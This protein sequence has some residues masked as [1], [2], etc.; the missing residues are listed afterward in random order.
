M[1]CHNFWRDWRKIGVLKE[2]QK[3]KKKKKNLEIDPNFA[4]WKMGRAWMMPY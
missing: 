1:G 3:R 2:K 4:N